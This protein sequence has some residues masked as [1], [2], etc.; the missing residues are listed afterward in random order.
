MNV[1]EADN[2]G[3][4]EDNV[5]YQS[6]TVPEVEVAIKVTALPVQPDPLV[7]TGLAGNALIV[8]CNV[9]TLSHPAALV[10]VCVGVA[11]D[12]Y[13]TPYQTKLPQAEA[14]VSPVFAFTIVKCNVTTESQPI[15]FV[16]VCVGVA[17]LL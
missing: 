14:V 1:F 3:V 6:T 9:T 13:V 7:T 10:K 5:S 16:K 11:D 4:A 17:E 15:S 12:V 8:K 2:N